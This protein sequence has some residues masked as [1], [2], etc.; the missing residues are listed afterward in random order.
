M[1]FLSARGL[2]IQYFLWP[3]GSSLDL[4]RRPGPGVLALSSLWPWESLSTCLSFSFFCKYGYSSLSSTTGRLLGDVW[5]WKHLVMKNWADLHELSHLVWVVSGGTGWRSQAAELARRW[6]VQGS[7][8]EWSGIPGCAE[9]DV[10]IAEQFLPLHA[11]TFSF[12][13]HAPTD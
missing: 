6:S 10:R 5:M 7:L 8:A 4:Y 1:G 11:C 12:L 9:Q 13:T 3:R 2:S